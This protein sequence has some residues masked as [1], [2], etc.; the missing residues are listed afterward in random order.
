MQPQKIRKAALLVSM[1][2]FPVTLNYFS[3][4]LIV[5][6]SFAGVAS[7]SFLLFAGLFLTSLV[8]G[9][10]FCGWIC[11]AGA[12]Q[13]ACGELNGK[14]TGPKQ[15]RI[16]YW[17]W[18]PWVA[19]IAAGFASAG[20]IK[21][22]QPFYF[23]DY[24]ISVSNNYAY[25]TYF[26]VVGLIAGTALL[27]GRRSFCHSLCWM[28]PFMV[29]GSRIKN[30]L[31]CPSLHLEAAVSKCVSCKSCDKAC[32]MSLPVSQMVMKGQMD[33]DECILCRNCVDGCHKDAIQ[34]RL[35]GRRR[36]PANRAKESNRIDISL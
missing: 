9:R 4:Y 14:P 7:G 36:P 31:G 29:L 17:V 5:Q 6:G 23:T 15:N 22:V 28:A 19:S 27:F 20:G 33:H 10:A 26:L 8:F 30:K 32:S 13:K 3:P 11:P 24:G 21:Q 16:K 25:I 18:A 12:L 2:V 35:G 1:L 34:I